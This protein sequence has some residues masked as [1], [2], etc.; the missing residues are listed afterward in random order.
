M[1]TQLLSELKCDLQ[2]QKC[3]SILG[4]LRRMQAFSSPELKLKFLQKRDCWFKEI[5]AAIPK[6]DSKSDE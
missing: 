4:F 3:L 1:I 5:L 2:L 6:N